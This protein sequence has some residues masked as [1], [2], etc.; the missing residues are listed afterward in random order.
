MAADRQRWS[1]IDSYYLSLP[2]FGVPPNSETSRDR[3]RWGRA[4]ACVHLQRRS[5]SGE[6]RNRPAALVH[7]W[8]RNSSRIPHE[9]RDESGDPLLRRLHY[10]RGRRTTRPRLSVPRSLLESE[11]PR[12]IRDQ[13]APAC[14]RLRRPVAQQVKYHPLLFSALPTIPPPTLHHNP[15]PSAFT[16]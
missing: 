4:L 7:A 1:A 12:R 16:V 13:N 11:Q 8:P 6:T 15:T 10:T 14:L 9:E 2:C 3:G 5:G